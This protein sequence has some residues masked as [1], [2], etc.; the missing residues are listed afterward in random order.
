MQRAKKPSQATVSLKGG[1]LIYT[2]YW[3]FVYGSTDGHI[4]RNNPGPFPTANTITEPVKDNLGFF[5]VKLAIASFS[6]LPQRVHSRCLE[7]CTRLNTYIMYRARTLRSTY[8]LC[9]ASSRRAS[10]LALST[11]FLY[12][13]KHMYA[14]YNALAR[15]WICHLCTNYLN[16]D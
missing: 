7:A 14:F 2:L 11:S 9:V 15:L 10:N 5:L 4:S 1:F 13:L 6:N 12:L 8:I 3:A 16:D